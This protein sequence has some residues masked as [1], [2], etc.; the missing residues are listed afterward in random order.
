MRIAVF[1]KSTT[2]H[3]GHGGLETQNKLLCEGLVAKGHSITVFAPKNDVSD[4]TKVE[5]G[6]SY[7]FIPCTYR[8][9]FSSINKNSWFNRSYQTFITQ[10]TAQEFDLVLGQSSAAV[11]IIARR[12]ELNNLPIVSISHGTTLG[13]L[14]TQLN[15][16]KSLKD[17][18]HILKSSQYVLRQFF[19]RQRDFVLKSSH[20]IA[21]STAV[22]NNLINE[23]YIPEDRVTVVNNGINPLPFS[24]VKDGRKFTGKTVLYVGQITRDKGVDIL[25]NMFSSDS[26]KNSRLV[27][28]GDGPIRLSLE[29][30][31]GDIGLTDRIKFLG[32]I[33]YDQIVTQYL[34]EDNTIFAFPT[35]REEGLP[36]VLVEALFSGLPVVAFNCGGVS[37]IVVDGHNG[38]LLD[39]KD[40]TS[41]D[42]KMQ[43]LLNNPRLCAQMSVN[44]LKD[45]YTKFTL[46]VMIEKYELV[47]RKVTQK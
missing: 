17:Y 26:Y 41:Y 37:D 13:E 23:T 14:K 33:K 46:D 40:Y 4:D 36:M 31:V 44:A 18:L 11:G 32:K 27:V 38:F 43:S 45:A 10:H 9:L 5:N 3:K 39:A 30:R 35:N 21:V 28:I 20:I 47:F 1:T 2:F 22:K 19:G 25:V 8:Y 12:T 42:Q 16:V 6:V 34:N 24:S 29:K 7:I 15:N